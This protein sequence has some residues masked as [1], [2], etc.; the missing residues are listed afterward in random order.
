MTSQR[1]EWTIEFYTDARGNSA[2]A[3]FIGGLPARERAKVRN[4]LRL[5]R[6]FGVLLRMPHARPVSEHRDLW[7][8]RPGAIRLFYFAHTGRR[9]IVLHAFRKKSRKAPRQEIAT[10][11]RRM[12]EFRERE[13]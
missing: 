7:E 4:A 12:A 1:S 6:E 10:A 11:E 2:V 13:Q 3:E 8:L 9:F 5:L